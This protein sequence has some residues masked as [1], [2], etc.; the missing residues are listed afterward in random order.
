[1]GKSPH[2]RYPLPIVKGNRPAARLGGERPETNMQS[3]WKERMLEFLQ[4]GVKGRIWFSLIDKI[5]RS[6][7]LYATWLTV[8]TNQG[9]A[10]S[11]R[12]SI[13]DFERELA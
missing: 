3:A 12:Q 6:S 11:D 8:K 10:G 2:G 5:V 13:Q 9:S 1:V 4:K 7:T